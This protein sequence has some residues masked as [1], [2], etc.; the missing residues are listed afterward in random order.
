MFQCYGDFIYPTDFV[1]YNYLKE[2][3]MDKMQQNLFQL[4]YYIKN[5]AQIL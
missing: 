2:Y 5:E 3:F 4:D 1:N